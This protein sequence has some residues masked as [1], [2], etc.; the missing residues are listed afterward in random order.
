VQLDAGKIIETTRH[1]QARITERFPGASLVEVSGEVV[2]AA[3]RAQDRSL[4]ISRPH[5]PLR[6]AR[7]ILVW[8]LVAMLAYVLHTLNPWNELKHWTG[9]KELISV[10]E[11]ALGT[12]VFIG[13]FGFF[14]WTLEDRWKL[15]KALAALH[16][17]RSLAHVID[18]H[19]LTKDPQHLLSPLPDTAHSPRREMTADHLGRYF[20]YCSELLA[21][22]SK[23]AALYAQNLSDPAA[24]KGVDEIENLAAGL[25]SK[26][27]QKMSLLPHFERMAAREEPPAEY[28]LPLPR[29]EPSLPSFGASGQPES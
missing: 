20:D 5:W 25:Q 9:I 21:M 23:V 17:L 1:L 13:A 27:W 18:I 12:A 14:V 26:V 15:R 2:L 8:G 19:Q 22:I 10:L 28:I 16:E 11:P 29:V 7:V 6:I 24:L 3:E 4:E